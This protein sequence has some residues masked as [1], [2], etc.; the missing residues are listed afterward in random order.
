MDRKE[1]FTK[2]I[3]HYTGSENVSDVE[4]CS[5]PSVPSTWAIRCRVNNVV[6]QFLLVLPG[7]ATTIEA[8]ADELDE[9]E[10]SSWPP[11]RK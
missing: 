9:V 2:A 7:W 6:V 8:I 11:S 4:I 5:D 10:F 1:K 3:I